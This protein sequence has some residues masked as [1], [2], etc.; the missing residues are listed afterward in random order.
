MRTRIRTDFL[1]QA[2]L[3]KGGASAPSS[4]QRQLGFIFRGWVGGGWLRAFYACYDLVKNTTIACLRR[5]D[6]F[7][8][9]FLELHVFFSSPRTTFDCRSEELVKLTRQFPSNLRA[10]NTNW[11]VSRT[12]CWTK[13]FTK[14]GREVS[15]YRFSLLVFLSVRHA[16]ITGDNGR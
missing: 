2:Q 5:S 13:M 15:A 14:I 12:F 16:V 11:L 7:P 10:R 6:F 9:P 1:T 8:H 3:W 4:D